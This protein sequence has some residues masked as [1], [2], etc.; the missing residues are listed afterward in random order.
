MKKVWKSEK[1]RDKSNFICNGGAEQLGELKPHLTVK[2]LPETEI[3]EIACFPREHA[4]LIRNGQ[5]N[6]FVE[7]KAEQNLNDLV[8]NKILNM[9]LE[10]E[11]VPGQKIVGSEL[12]NQLGISRTP[13]NHA[14]YHLYKESY[15]DF[16]QNHGYTV[17]L[18]TRE[19]TDSL[20][21]LR[22]IIE[23]GAIEK[24]INKIAPDEIGKMF[25]YL[26]NYGTAVLQN[27]LN[28]KLKIDFKFHSALIEH[29]ENSIL[30]NS[31]NDILQK[32]FIRHRITKL[33]GEITFTG[34]A[35]H[36][37][38]IEAIRERN[39]EKAKQAIKTHIKTGKE[40]FYS[41]NY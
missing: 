38:L 27:E 18:S 4:I 16:E 6:V 13:L 3:H 22:E 9:I 36:L 14:L 32:I 40:Y 11:L 7:S 26:Q 39:V 21:E 28:G 30:E 35:E 1:L 15:L 37:E 19:E 17:H 41:F 31:Y 24:I 25:N 33:H 23:L 10:C 29:V 8:Y 12:A 34:L 5:E 2:R 20:Y